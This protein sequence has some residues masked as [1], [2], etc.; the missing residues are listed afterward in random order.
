MAYRGYIVTIAVIDQSINA[1]FIYDIDSDWNN[2][3]TEEF[4]I[5]Q[6][7]HLSNCSWGLFDGEITDLRGE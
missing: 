5:S 2:E 7:R 6:G 3:E 4:L 1:L